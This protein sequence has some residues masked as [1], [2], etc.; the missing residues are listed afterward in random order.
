MEVPNATLRTLTES[1]R[2]TNVL[3][4]ELDRPTI[5][6]MVSMASSIAPIPEARAI[7]KEDEGP[8][9]ED[10]DSGTPEKFFGRQPPNIRKFEGLGFAD[11]LT[12]F[13]ISIG[14]IPY[15]N[16]AFK[17]DEPVKNERFEAKREAM[18]PA[19]QRRLDNSRFKKRHQYW[20][21]SNATLLAILIEATRDFSQLSSWCLT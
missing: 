9:S 18:T 11:W 7:L 2:R 3:L 20:V 8:L 14:T 16:Y 1:E 10:S 19:N 15:L 17:Y 21:Q 12:S 13:V 6:N 5:A 4:G